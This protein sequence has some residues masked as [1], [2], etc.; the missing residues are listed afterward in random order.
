M[1]LHNTSAELVPGTFKL[2]GNLSFEKIIAVL[3][4]KNNEGS[5]S[6]TIPEGYDI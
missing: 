1:K 4:N 5:I 2:S 6:V 3:E